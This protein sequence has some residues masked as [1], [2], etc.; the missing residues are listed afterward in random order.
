[1]KTSS[2]VGKAALAGATLVL[3]TAGFISAQGASAARVGDGGPAPRAFL[4]KLDSTPTVRTFRQNRDDGISAARQAARSQKSE[5]ARDQAQVIDELP[6]D[7]SVIYRTHSLLA[8]VGVT[9]SS[10]DQTLL[11]QIPGVSAVYPIAPKSI[12]NANAVPFQ[13]APAAWTATGFLGQ[14]ET[15][16]VIDTGVDYTHSNFG[17]PGT[18][19][20]YDTA[21][22]GEATAANPALFPN[23]KVIGGIDLVGDNYDTDPDSDNYQPNPNPDPNPLDCGGHGSHVAGSAAGYGVNAGGGTYTGAYDNSTDFGAM[24]IGPGMAPEADIYAIKVFGCDGSTDVVAE[25]TGRSRRIVRKSSP[26][27]P[28]TSSPI[29]AKRWRRLTPRHATSTWCSII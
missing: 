26:G 13:S 20:A 10:G 29:F 17:G 9:A 8:G 23:D 2:R 12:R 25:V 14:G 11:E 5:I 7:A 24:K 21:H 6:A 22:A 27:G 4:L 18:V 15:I 19:S 1:M 28:N 16:A 3:A